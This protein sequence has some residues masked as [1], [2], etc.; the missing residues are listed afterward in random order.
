MMNLNSSEAK[1]V[2][3]CVIGY[4]L[5]PDKDGDCLFGVKYYLKPIDLNF[6]RGLFNINMKSR[7]VG[8][9]YVLDC[10]L[11]N[12]EQALALQPYVIDGEINLKKYKFYLQ[13]EANYIGEVLDF[14]KP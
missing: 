10:F 3:R 13:T 9:L 11:I 14:S 5:I 6:L 1:K 7:D 12:E 4:N 8:E 2:K